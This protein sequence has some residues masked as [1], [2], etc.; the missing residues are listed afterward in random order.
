MKQADALV[1]TALEVADPDAQI[2]KEVIELIRA[3]VVQ[4]I[5]SYLHGHAN[6]MANAWAFEAKHNIKCIALAAIKDHFNNP[7]YIASI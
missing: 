3:V 4:E 6:V 7:M 1:L 5:A 2:R